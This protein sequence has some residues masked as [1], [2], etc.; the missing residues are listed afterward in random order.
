MDR[1]ATAPAVSIWGDRSDQPVRRP[2]RQPACRQIGDRR[3]AE[4]AGGQH[5]DQVPR[6]RRVASPQAWAAAP[7]RSPVARGQRRTRLAAHGPH[8]HGPRDIRHPR[9]GVRPGPGRRQPRLAGPAGPN[10][11]RRRHRHRDRGR[12]LRHPPLPQ[13]RH[14]ARRHG[15][16]PH[17]QRRSTREGGCGA[18]VLEGSC[19]GLATLARGSPRLPTAGRRRQRS[20]PDHEAFG[21]RRVTTRGK[22]P[23]S[24]QRSST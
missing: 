10:P 5:R 23:G 11:G 22:A 1:P 18:Q 15:D 9:G 14:R 4:P 16:H 7:A 19:L 13:P 12:R 6:R 24:P 17:P 21:V 8:G 3:A 2:R 20:G